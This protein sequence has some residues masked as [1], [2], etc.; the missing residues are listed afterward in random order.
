MGTE[1]TGFNRRMLD[2][3]KREQFLE[4]LSPQCGR[5]GGGE[6]GPQSTSGICGEGELRHQQQTAAGVLQRQIHAPLGIAEDA[7]AKQFLQQ[8]PDLR[9]AV[10]RLYGDQR[11]QTAA[12]PPGASILDIDA[13]FGDALDQGDHADGPRRQ[14]GAADYPG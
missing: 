7:V 10:A 5:G 3:C 13:C 6:A 2:P 14:A 1:L 12:D 8:A 9:R 4:A 11:Q